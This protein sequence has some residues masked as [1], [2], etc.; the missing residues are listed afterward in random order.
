VGRVFGVSWMERNDVKGDDGSV[1]PIRRLIDGCDV[2]CR[3]LSPATRV[4]DV[5]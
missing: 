5:E 4:D 3:R 2:Q 1:R